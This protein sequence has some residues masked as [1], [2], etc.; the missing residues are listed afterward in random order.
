M[1]DPVAGGAYDPLMI[2]AWQLP[3]LQ[4]AVTRDTVVALMVKPETT[5]FDY[6]SGTLQIVV[7]V[8]GLFA[9]IAM[10][11]MAITLRKTIA[12][13]QTTVDRITADTKP[14]LHQA[15]RLSEDAHDV[16]KTVRREV[17]R[18]AEATGEVS[19]RILDLSDSAEARI[20]EVNALIDVMQDEI[21][22]TA[23]SAAAAVRGVR[24]GAMAL[25]AALGRGGK[26][27]RRPVRKS[28]RIRARD[29]EASDEPF[30]DED[31][32]DELSVTAERDDGDEF[33]D[34]ELLDDDGSDDEI[35]DD[36]LLDDDSSD[37]EFDD[38]ET[39]TRAADDDAAVDEDD[40]RPYYPAARRPST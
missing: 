34:D 15:T 17:D 25:G 13:L 36:E 7:L 26:K 12:S 23:L 20:D 33:D 1:L 5:A 3:L 37:D 28:P 38:D 4:S 21:Q 32:E 6:A 14:L 19:E 24:V 2:I 35:D 22:D 30:F 10:G 11:L 18:L 16:V 9:L 39:D 8:V 31:D 29:E 27:K 40:D